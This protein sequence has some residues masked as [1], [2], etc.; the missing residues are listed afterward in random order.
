MNVQ[1]EI[2]WIVSEVSKVRD[3]ELINAFKSMLKYRKKH[4]QKDL[5]S[6]KRIPI[7]KYNT[8]I[9]AAEKRI[10]KGKFTKHSDLEK[11]ARAW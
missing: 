7:E 1:A 8:E 5:S 9:E 3:P 6:E 10:A 2:N 11:E 4:I